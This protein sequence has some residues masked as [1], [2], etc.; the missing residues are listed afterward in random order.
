MTTGGGQRLATA[1]RKSV[2]DAIRRSQDFFRSIQHDDGYWWGRLESNPTME[3]EYLM[4]SLFLGKEDQLRKN[5]RWSKIC[6][7][8]LNEQREDG[9]W[10]LYYGAP[11]D[12]STSVECYFALKLAGV[13]ADS[14]EM[15]RAR[16]FILA[17][18][19]VPGCRVFTKIW[20]ALFGQ[21]DWN[22]LPN[23][24]PEM[25][26]VPPS[27]PFSVYDFASWARPLC[28]CS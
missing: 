26:L 27:L 17:R 5:G 8:I 21:W 22:G 4:L 18:G 3:A 28:R 1:S 24:P 7:T 20:L 12:L 10:G 6:R 19:G 9:S 25:I 2:T 13:P 16:D 11:G 14:D 23:M 15:V